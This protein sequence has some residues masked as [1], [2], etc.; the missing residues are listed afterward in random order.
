MIDIGC[1]IFTYIILITLRQIPSVTPIKSFYHEKIL[2]FVEK[3]FASI[4]IMW[5]LSFILLI[6]HMTSIDL[7]MLNH[8]CIPEISP[9]CSW[10]TVL[11]MC[12][13]IQ[14]ASFLLKA[15]T[16]VFPGNIG[17]RFSCMFGFGIRV[18]NNEIFRKENKETIPY[19]IASNRIKFSRINL[20]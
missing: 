13:L 15:F 18:N 12:C 2:D 4:V 5:F 10:C 3:N 14:F 8:P 9:R 11:L 7:L 19:T 17:L 6:W 1:G 20:T 16:P